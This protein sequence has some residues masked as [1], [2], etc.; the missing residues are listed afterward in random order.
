MQ[1]ES[2]TPVSTLFLQGAL[3]L[4]PGAQLCEEISE[5]QKVMLVLAAF[6]LHIFLLI[7]RYFKLHCLRAFDFLGKAY[8]FEIFFFFFASWKNILQLFRRTS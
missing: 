7:N 5:T 3:S 8:H 1:T 2:N 4:E 6:D